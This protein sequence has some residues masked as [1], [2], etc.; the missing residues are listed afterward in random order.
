MLQQTQ[1]ATVIPYY[2]RFL[3]RF[4]TVRDL[5]AADV[6]DVLRLWSG[7][8]YYAR[9]RN[10]LCAARIVVERHDGQFPDSLDALRELP[11][12]GRYTAGAVASIAFDRRSAIVDG[13]VARVLA[14]VFRVRG[15]VS[16]G[17]G[18]AR[19]WSIAESLLP[20]RRCGDFNQ[21]LMELG[22]QVCMPGARAQC[23]D[24]PL[25]SRCA[26]RA[27]G[28]VAELPEKRRRTAARSET[29]VVA[30]IQRRRRWLFVRRPPDGLW[31][32]LW[33]LPTAVS[34]GRS[35]A[36][37][38][39]AVLRLAADLG[40]GDAVVESRPAARTTRRLTHR[41]IRF[42][43]YRAAADH[44][45]GAAPGVPVE[46]RWLTLDEGCYFGLSAAM[47]EIVRQLKRGTD[48]R[49]VPGKQGAIAR[50]RAHARR[51]GVEYHGRPTKEH[52]SCHASSAAV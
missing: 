35:A 33:S 39:S 16:C 11:G 23:G 1:A 25:A 17:S 3:S 50:S 15:D 9:A 20:R 31:G 12:V 21:A 5:A 30:A 44:A 40:L 26:A 43:T 47:T 6:Q 51:D 7:L 29:H 24:C 22:A 37:I 49:Q 52:P 8:G 32:G 41:A 42:V 46:H 38:R 2:R 27:A 4:P 10:L 19:L 28:E 14:R 34:T 13:N 48:G 18:R 36:A 45:G